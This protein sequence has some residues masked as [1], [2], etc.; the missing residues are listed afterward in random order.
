MK[1]RHLGALL[2]AL[3]S[4]AMAVDFDWSGFATL[5]YAI[6]DKPYRYQRVIDEEGSFARDSVLGGQLDIRLSPR[7]SA[8][9]QA[10]LAP[11]T[12]SDS[13]WDPTLSWAFLAWRPLDDLMV[14]AGKLRVPYMLDTENHDVGVT[15]PYARLPTE[16]YATTPTSDIYGLMLSLSNW[17]ALGEWTVDGYYGRIGSHQRIYLRSATGQPEQRASYN[18]TRM[19]GGGVVF[20]LRHDEDLY[21]LGLHSIRT[22]RRSGTITADF[23]FS[24]LPAPPYQPGE[25]FYDLSNAPQTGS[26]ITRMLTLGASIE[27]PAAFR[28]SAEYVRLLNSRAVNGWNRWAA[29]AALS[30]RVGEWT[31][32][33]YLARMQSGSQVLKLYDAVIDNRLSVAFPPVDASQRAVADLLLAHDQGTLA[34]GTSY[35]LSSNTLLKA[36]WAQTRTWRVSGFVD[37]LPGKDSADLR[38]NVLSLSWNLTF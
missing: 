25:G 7:L 17:N 16:V 2:L 12:D 11:S 14:R 4:L 38:I 22:E 24:P 27:L 19:Q 8:T 21:R 10:R 36:E 23:P 18:P 37:P 6:S 3:P 29:Y 35:R 26:S 20:S 33:I 34:L 13:G 30:R 15:Y 32:Y 28:F 9:L 31:P 5:G 1:L